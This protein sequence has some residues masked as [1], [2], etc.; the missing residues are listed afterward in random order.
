MWSDTVMSP[1]QR[2]I[3]AIQSEADR[4]KKFYDDDLVAFGAKNIDDDVVL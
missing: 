2:V 3:T 1:R 4:V